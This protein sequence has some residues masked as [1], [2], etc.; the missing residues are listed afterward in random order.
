MPRTPLLSLLLI[1]SLAP[2]SAQAQQAPITAPPT[3]AAAALC[4]KF[5]ADSAVVKD[6]CYRACA[7]WPQQPQC[8]MLR[9][10]GY[11]GWATGGAI[12]QAMQQGQLPDWD[13]V[14]KRH[15]HLRDVIELLVFPPHVD[16]PWRPEPARALV[17]QAIDAM[18]RFQR[19]DAAGQYSSAIEA[20]QDAELALT[21]A[22]GPDHPI[23]AVAINNHALALWH[24]GRYPDAAKTYQRAIK[25]AS[26]SLGPE[27]PLL[28]TLL[29]NLGVIREAMG[30]YA[31]S[32]ADIERAL[33]INLLTAGPDNPQRAIILNNLATTLHRLGDQHAARDAA[34][35]A[36]ALSERVKGVDPANVG[37]ILGNLATIHA[38]MGELGVARDYYERDLRHT[39]STLGPKHP[40]VAQD[41]NN[42]ATLLFDL[43]DLPLARSYLDRALDI[44]GQTVGPKH[45][46]YAET[47]S[48][49]A[50]VLSAQGQHADAAKL[51]AQALSI[52]EESLGRDHPDI[53]NSLNNLAQLLARAREHK[54]ARQAYE[55]AISIEERALGTKHPRLATP[56]HNLGISLVAL[57]EHDAGLAA[58]TRA[59]KLGEA[60][61]GKD[62]PELAGTLEVIAMLSALLKRSDA[63]PNMARAAS[64]RR[65]GFWA[66]A[67]AADSDAQLLMR[68]AADDASTSALLALAWQ[69]GRSDALW[70]ELL[71]RTG[72][73]ARAEQHRRA[74]QHQPP[75]KR[76]ANPAALRVSA[77]E[78]CAILRAEQ[79]AMIHWLRQRPG[80]LDPPD[81][82]DSWRAVVVTPAAKKGCD[83]KLVELGA[84]QPLDAAISAWRDQITAVEQRL[85]QRK[86][87][88]QAKQALHDAG[89]ALDR[90]AWAPLLPALGAI[91]RAYLVP[92]DQLLD[93]ALG[94]LPAPDGL[95]RAESLDLVYLPVP[96][97]L[98]RPAAAPTQGQG[99]LVLGALDFAKPAPATAEL[100]AASWL[101]CQGQACEAAPRRAMR[102]VASRGAGRACGW[103]RLGWPRVGLEAL[104]VAAALGALWRG[105]D[106]WLITGAG[107]Q[108]A[109]LE[110]AMPGRRLLH[111]GTH[112]F[113]A[114]AIGCEGAVQHTRAG[115]LSDAPPRV[116]IDPMQLSALVL[117][118]AD[119]TTPDAPADQDGALTAREIVG[120][121]LSSVEVATLAACETGRGAAVA[122][123]GAQGLSKAFLVAGV[124]EVIVSLWQVPDGET[125]RLMRDLY[126]A[127]PARY[128]PGQAARALL[129]AQ[130]KLA[131]ELRAAGDP[132][133]TFSWAA[134]IPLTSG[135]AFGPRR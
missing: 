54:L 105:Q 71:E 82:Q 104:E 132:H 14:H 111:F 124:R 65:A 46:K 20:A 123:E 45:P 88:Q 85:T 11:D 73:A 56:L 7:Q 112:G 8:G 90:L 12:L 29:D 114:P 120:I 61:L 131:A 94:A 38:A 98:T 39:E 6:A 96:A 43:N 17:K 101:R 37:H 32:R 113:F 50:S 62:S 1:L 42:L 116:G 51:A 92:Q 75:K 58:L 2:T 9:R 24:A 53:A 79:A 48:N 19:F 70:A 28:A 129:T 41:L 18:G 72:R 63:W 103:Q 30:D 97:N 81:A 110:A 16:P 93:V 76:K 13:A 34:L 22:L 118:G 89:A 4:A 83:V 122:G 106:V 23:T 125:A 95:A 126:A 109:A 10:F 67:D 35:Q 33:A 80:P 84:A 25:A 68:S 3:P 21:R 27:D 5:E 87:P 49:L 60:A 77:D 121:D 40:D 44:Y 99:A 15:P 107:A 115:F 66:A 134:F 119:A 86:P 64:L 69:Q 133:A 52:R 31:G 78:T 47:L 91:K 100:A 135:P 127:L 130:R 55:R 36:L 128:E 117:S 108:Q 74:A 57:G 26:A 59:L 102:A